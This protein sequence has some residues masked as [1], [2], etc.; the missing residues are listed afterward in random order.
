MPDEK[1]KVPEMVCFGQYASYYFNCKFCDSL[2]ECREF[3]TARRG[4]A[5]TKHL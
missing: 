3:T 2:Q 4:R 1:S 5:K